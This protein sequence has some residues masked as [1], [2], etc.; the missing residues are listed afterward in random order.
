MNQLILGNIMRMHNQWGRYE[1]ANPINYYSMLLLLIMW[2]GRN[3]WLCCKSLFV[4]SERD[5]NWIKFLIPF[6]QNNCCYFLCF[7]NST[8][9]FELLSRFH[10]MFPFSYVSRLH[11]NTDW[12]SI[13]SLQT[14]ASLYENGKWSY[15]DSLAGHCSCYETLS[16]GQSSSTATHAQSSIMWV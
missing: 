15:G 5:G 10:N 13:S 6:H 8:C 7:G 9:C 3:Y 2:R 16:T 12:I 1:V 11:F 14:I 4:E